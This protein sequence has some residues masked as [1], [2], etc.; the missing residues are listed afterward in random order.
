MSG[1]AAPTLTISQLSSTALAKKIKPFTLDAV[2]PVSALVDPTT[3]KR[4]GSS[5]C[6]QIRARR[7]VHAHVMRVC[8]SN[9]MYVP[10]QKSLWPNEQI[11]RISPLSRE[12][13]G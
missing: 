12:T 3:G 1:A 5:A 4:Q 10:E 6:R 7:K 2:G 8:M 13:Q 11:L 9:N